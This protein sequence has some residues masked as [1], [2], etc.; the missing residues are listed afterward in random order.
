MKVIRGISNI[1]RFPLPVVALGV[2]DGVH[3]GHRSILSAAVETA[4]EIRGTSVAVTFWP[5]PQN[6]K[7]LYSL[8][9]RLRIIGELGLQAA[10]VIKFTGAF[11]RL[12]AE[13]F[14]KD[15]L[16]DRISA[17]YIFI[18]KN[19]HFGKDRKG[20]YRLLQRSSARNN[21]KV[22]VF[23]IIRRKDMPISSTLLRE[24]ISRGELSRA[25]QLLLRP[26]SVLGTVIKGESRGSSL[27]FPTA[28]ID[29]H[30]E[31]LP[32]DGIYAVRVILGGKKFKG[33]CYIGKKPTFRKHL[34]NN[35][36]CEEAEEIPRLSLRGTAGA[37]AISITGSEQ[38]AQSQKQDC[39]AP[40]LAGRQ[41]SGLAMTVAGQ[42]PRRRESTG[43]EVH[44][45]GFHRNIYAKT[46]E[47]QFIKK[48]REDRKFSSALKLSGQI[49][50]DISRAKNIF[51][52][53]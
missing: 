46:L 17:R 43:I 20:D 21:F 37:E 8:E 9:H 24:L 35:R 49:K 53:T 13:R 41:A 40:C 42:F 30:H 39:F 50:K 29:P 11:S 5:H 52:H 48:I 19:F 26:V 25:R 22:R 7:S 44:I 10:I 18:G 6:R 36:H 32:P 3:L 14:V 28:N 31:V 23:E 51:S 12:S 45:L 4:K 27:G 34:S 33:V 1:R 38:A 2:F 16:V 15:I 47:I